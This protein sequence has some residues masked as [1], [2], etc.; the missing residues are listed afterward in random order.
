[1]E[2]LFKQAIKSAEPEPELLEDIEF[3]NKIIE[4]MNRTYFTEDYY[5]P[6]I[7]K[8]VFYVIGAIFILIVFCGSISNLPVETTSIFSD[9]NV[10]WY[11]LKATLSLLL[12]LISVSLA[13]YFIDLILLKPKFSH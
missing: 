7:P 4:K 9:I 1:M 11:D 6:L 12:K 10:K 3:T 5:R 2:D 13:L 8:G